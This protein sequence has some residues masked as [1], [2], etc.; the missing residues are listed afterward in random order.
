MPQLPQARD[1]GSASVGV[2]DNPTITPGPLASVV[3]HIFDQGAEG[4][5]LREQKDD[6]DGRIWA[7]KTITEARGRYNQ[8]IIDAQNSGEDLTGYLPKVTKQLQSDLD[9]A[10]KAAPNERGAFHLDIAAPDFAAD[11]Q[12]AAQVAEARYRVT[13]RV[14]DT[15]D[16]INQNRN[17]V[18]TNPGQ[19]AK[20]Y[21]ETKTLVDGLSLPIEAKSKLQ[22]QV[23]GL[24]ASAVQGMIENGNPY[25]AVKQLKSGA[26]G[27][28]LDADH[29]A[30]LTNQ[31]QSE[32]K[33]REAEARERSNA[34]SLATM[35]GLAVQIN[36][37]NNGQGEFTQENLDAAKASLKPQAFNQLQMAFDD[38]RAQRAK[39]DSE[40]V[41]VS[42]IIEA[43]GHIDP[44]N[45]KQVKAY[46]A[47]FR[48]S[49]LPQVDASVASL[50]PQDQVAAK[51]AR[52]LD[53][54]G[55]QGIVPETVRADTRASLRAGTPEQKVEAA[56]FLDSVKALN[57]QA[58]NDFSQED[59]RLGNLIAASI[60]QGAEPADAVRAAT[61]ALVQPKEI[62]QALDATYDKL[63]KDDT[64]A[65]WLGA[66]TGGWWSTPS[67]SPLI[68]AEVDRTV[69]SEFLRNGGN[70]E[71]ARRTALDATKKRYGP[72][73]VN[74][75]EV[76]RNPVEQHYGVPWKTPS[77][78]AAAIKAEAISDV[79]GWTDG[80]KNASTV[81]VLPYPLKGV[82]APDGRPVYAIEI[83]NSAGQWTVRIDTDEKS[84]T[85]GMPKPWW[86]SLSKL[87][88]ERDEEVKRATAAAKSGRPGADRNLMPGDLGL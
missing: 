2:P 35:S 42:S 50:P 66:K 32:I 19:F 85:F 16:I 87:K 7:A 62:S 46:D 69:R 60:D 61:E 22:D 63:T 77:E 14:A 33:R 49:F 65:D 10:R 64:T 51:S 59:I 39:A 58:L 12:N 8:S 9:A 56:R 18:F 79:S 53:F 74:G 3:G 37:F 13:K 20:S 24:A 54:I 40:R 57:A 4:L 41:N 78:N 11:V 27:N 31:A 15:E 30:A 34:A 45:E 83:Q 71:A 48:Q 80:P 75:Y 86:P 82:T 5:K 23:R 55:K 76:T 43:G 25:E 21:T 6:E 36:R 29:M 70:L 1:F 84:P 81:R 47:Y 73:E 17:Q 88:A 68:G 26:W 52:I 44:G 38:A 67:V 72:S 28:Y